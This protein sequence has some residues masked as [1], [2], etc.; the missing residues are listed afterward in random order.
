MSTSFSH[1]STHQSYSATNI[2][3]MQC[4]KMASL[5]QVPEDVPLFGKI[6]L[7]TLVC[8][9]CGFKW[10]DVM[11]LEFREPCGFEAHVKSEKDLSIKIVRNSSGTIEIPELGVLLEPGPFAEGFFTNMEGLLERVLEVISTLTRSQ[12]PVQKREAKARYALVKE[13]QSGKHPFTVRVLDPLGGSALLGHGVKRFAL[14]KEEVS[15]LKRGIHF[16]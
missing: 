6:M 15:Q 14:S 11:S 10:S 16:S 12:D 8:S 13:A 2:P 7:Q 4:Q 5:I 1:E 9:H 3:C